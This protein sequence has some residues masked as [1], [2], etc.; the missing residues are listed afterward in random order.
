MELAKTYQQNEKI[1]GILLAGSVSRGWQDQHSDIEL[2]IL[3]SEPPSD[4]ERLSPIEKVNGKILGFFP[5]EDEEWSETYLTI[6]NIKIE[7]SNFLTETIDRYIDDVVKM[8]EID[9]DK[10]CILASIHFGYSLSGERLISILKNKVQFY[11]DKLAENMILSHLDLG[12]RWINRRALL[13]RSDWLMLYEVICSVQQKLMATLLGLNKL[14]VH[15]PAFKW[16]HHTIYSID[17]KPKNLDKR[18]TN[19]LVGDVN[20]S[21]T[22]LEMLVEEV[23]SLVKL[24]FPHI[25]IDEYVQRANFLRPENRQ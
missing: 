10:Q 1:K 21:I 4:L 16:M 5:Y 3:W 23:Q 9:Y 22:E 7:V 8:Y 12:S 13:D 17:I 18:L 25:E 24:Y 6:E 11:P 14:Y 20:E 2:H 19:I 15:H